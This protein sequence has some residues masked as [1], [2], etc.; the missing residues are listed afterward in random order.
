M[1]AL[2]AVLY[3]FTEL[4][5]QKFWDLL[6]F[7][8][9]KV[10]FWQA[11][12]SSPDGDVNRAMEFFSFNLDVWDA[13]W[14][15]SH[16]QPSFLNFFLSL[17]FIF[18]TIIVFSFLIK[19]VP[20]IVDS[21]IDIE[22]EGGGG[23]TP[24]KGFF[25]A[26]NETFKIE[27]DGK[28]RGISNFAGH[29]VKKGVK[30]VGSKG[31]TL[32]GRAIKG[33]VMA[34]G[35]SKA[36]VNLSRTFGTLGKLVDQALREGLGGQGLVDTVINRYKAELDKDKGIT[37]KDKKNRIDF[38]RQSLIKSHIAAPIESQLEHIGRALRSTIGG[39]TPESARQILEHVMPSA[40]KMAGVTTGETADYHEFMGLIDQHKF[41]RTCSTPGGAD[42]SPAGAVK[43][44]REAMMTA[45]LAKCSKQSSDDG[46]YPADTLREVSRREPKHQSEI[47]MILEENSKLLGYEATLQLGECE[48]SIGTLID[49]MEVLRQEV[50]AEIRQLHQQQQDLDIPAT[51]DTLDTPADVKQIYDLVRTK[52]D[53]SAE[54]ITL[55]KDVADM[56]QKLHELQ[57]EIQTTDITPKGLPDNF[58]MGSDVGKIVADL[59]HGPTNLGVGSEYHHPHTDDPQHPARDNHWNEGRLRMQQQRRQLLQY[60]RLRA[61]AEG[62]ATLTASIDEQLANVN[63]DIS[64]LERQ[65]EQD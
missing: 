33:H 39:V 23:G 43:A 28:T 16:P 51:I 55:Q 20:T 48:K 59:C 62:N 29:L 10:P 21:M 49:H 32:A 60:Q 41:I 13:Q 8:V 47:K 9:C 45:Q 26:A 52:M 22:G 54:L 2:F 37:E 30:F 57:L 58:A 1:V 31:V 64:R 61:Q 24:N 25:A 46:E 19:K 17:L 18:F 42:L 35:G 5:K 7:S 63:R 4:V 14:S 65:L 12:A 56:Q 3:G 6:S 53:H 38:A 44:A 36:A 40:C 11:I 15:T 50:E 34:Y 27:Y